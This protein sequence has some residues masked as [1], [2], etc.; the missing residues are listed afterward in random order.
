MKKLRLFNALI[1][2]CLLLTTNIWGQQNFQVNKTPESS[3]IT[4]SF[5]KPADWGDSPV[6]LWAWTDDNP[7]FLGE[8]WPGIPISEG[9]NGFSSYT[10]DS[11][12]KIVNIIFSKDGSPQS[13][14]IT[15]VVKSTCYEF[16]A[17]VSENTFS[18]KTVDCPAPSYTVSVSANPA[19]GGTV[20]GG[21]SYESGT[22]C[23]V[24]AIAY[25]GYIFTGWTEN[26]EVVST[27][28]SYTFT[29]EKDRTL[30][31]NFEEDDSPFIPIT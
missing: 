5:K 22:S 8:D 7:Q 30:T 17:Y 19:E 24:T 16:D 23:T 26:N 18:V 11:S 14:N 31:A 25:G 15:N 20:T 6:Y 1:F 27:E 9:E 28:L 13:T 29:V 4:V 21:G 10:F 2:A 12:V 3:A